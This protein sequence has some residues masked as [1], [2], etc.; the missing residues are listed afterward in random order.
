M[1]VCLSVLSQIYTREPTYN[2]FVSL[3]A[4]T[5]E[6]GD[7]SQVPGAPREVHGE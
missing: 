6:P 7:E 3:Y 5:E 4:G 1:S 2:V